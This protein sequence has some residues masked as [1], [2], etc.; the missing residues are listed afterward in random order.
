MGQPGGRRTI[1]DAMMTV[2]DSVL[3]PGGEVSGA[4]KPLVLAR[5]IGANAVFRA[6]TGRC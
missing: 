4:G 1:H 5:G 2:N 3:L 6:F